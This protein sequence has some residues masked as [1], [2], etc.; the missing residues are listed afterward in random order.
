[1][2]G[3]IWF[4]GRPLRSQVS[5]TAKESTSQVFQLLLS[6]PRAKREQLQAWW[7][8]L[9]GWNTGYTD[10][11]GKKG[12]REGGGGI[13]CSEQERKVLEAA[14]S[15]Q[16]PAC[17]YTKA[18]PLAGSPHSLLPWPLQSTAG[19]MHSLLLTWISEWVHWLAPFKCHSH[20]NKRRLQAHCP[21]GSTS[22]LYFL[23]SS[24]QLSYYQVYWLLVSLKKKLT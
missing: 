17:T 20:P 5:V 2:K 18:W 24:S 12:G 23:W 8:R 7:H 21:N 11:Q 13:S 9:S 15:W 10:T 4:C 19:H 16:S 14:R 6:K 1:M 3:T 22:T